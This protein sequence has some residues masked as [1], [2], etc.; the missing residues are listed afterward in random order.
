M[1]IQF[2]N[3]SKRL[4]TALARHGLFGDTSE[5]VVRRLVEEKLREIVLQGWM[6]V[7]GEPSGETQPL[8]TLDQKFR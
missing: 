2:S 3:S 5:E 7:P 8:V 6:G 4:I 1:K